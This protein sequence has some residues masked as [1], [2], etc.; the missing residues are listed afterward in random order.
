MVA[1]LL[2]ATKEPEVIVKER[3]MLRSTTTTTY[4]YM[5]RD[6]LS[7]LANEGPCY[8]VENIESGYC[9]TTTTTVAPP[10]PPVVVLT[11]PPTTVQPSTTTTAVTS[12]S[13]TT[14]TTVQETTTTQETVPDGSSDT[15]SDL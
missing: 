9:P 6:D 1:V 3:W 12:P 7:H 13:T 8:R 11:H 4:E 14:T 10:P 15:H 2:G 5:P